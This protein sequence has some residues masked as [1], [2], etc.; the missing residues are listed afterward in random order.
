MTGKCNVHI[1]RFESISQM[2]HA[3][4]TRPTNSV[5]TGARLES[6]RDDYSF[7]RTHSYDEALNLLSCGWEEPLEKIKKGVSSNFKSNTTLNKSRPQTGV[8]GYA[9]CVPNAIMGLP[10]S[11]IATEKTPSKVKAVTI[12]FSMSVTGGYSQENILKA[13][14]VI[15]NII[16]DLELAGYRVRLDVEFFGAGSSASST[17]NR[18]CSARVNVKDW[19]QPLDL[20]KLAFPISHPSMFRR[21]GFHWVETY[22]KLTDRAYRSGYGSSYFKEGYANAKKIFEENGL[23]SKNEYLITTYL[24]MNKKYDKE[25]IIKACGLES[26]RNEGKGA[27]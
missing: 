14:I 3:I 20:K 1:E 11:M 2:L 18:I 4:E 12:L 19:R 10:N 6:K 5:F 23:L 15:L 16:N 27:R 25:E 21:F 22:P 24:C 9:P 13:G 26:V 7:T 17:P 8:V